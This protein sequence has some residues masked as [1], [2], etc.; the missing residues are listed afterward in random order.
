MCSFGLRAQLVAVDRYANCPAG[1]K[2]KPD[3]DGFK[4]NLEAIVGYRPDLVFVNDNRDG[5]VDALRRANIDVVYLKIPTTLNGVLDQ[6]VVLGRLTGKDKEAQ[7]LTA[8]LRE[9]IDTVRA[10]ASAAPSQP[11]VYV[12]IDP[13]FFSASPRSFIGDFLN[14][15]RSQNIAAGSPQ[16]YPQLTAEVIVQRDPEVIILAE[17]TSQVTPETAKARS[18]WSQI[19]AVRNNRICQLDPDVV[20]RPGARL[21]EALDLVAKCVH[22]DL[23]P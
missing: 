2:E 3:L 4:P 18:G 11:R 21:G 23:F 15:V 12:E 14:V 8:T 9:K 16:E 13:K 6:L 5:I 10:K 20:S 22:P 7:T 17:T 1:S 19:S